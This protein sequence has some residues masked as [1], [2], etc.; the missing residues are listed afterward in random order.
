MKVTSNWIPCTEKIPTVELNGDKVLLYRLM[1]PSQSSLALNIYDTNMVK[2][3]NANETW[4][5]E[6]PKPP[7]IM[8]KI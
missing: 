4:W 5:M 1:N 3:C 8:E 7:S 2:H 6:L